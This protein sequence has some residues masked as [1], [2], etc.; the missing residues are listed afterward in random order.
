M[1]TPTRGDLTAAEFSA[2]LG[3][4]P[5][6]T[7][8]G[9]LQATENPRDFLPSTLVQAGVA[10][11]LKGGEYPVFRAALF[12]IVLTL[13]VGQNAGLLCKVWCYPHDATAGC[14]QQ[15]PT[16]SPSV[17]GD[18]YCNN[19]ALGGRPSGPPMNAIRR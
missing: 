2:S 19:V 6:V 1:K 10:L 13:A 17:S 12:S 18:D 8:S 11:A 16:T 4:I 15:E 9:S 14:R 3:E 5:Q 7:R